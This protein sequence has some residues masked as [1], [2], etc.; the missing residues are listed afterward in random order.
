MLESIKSRFFIKLIFS[1]IEEEKKLKIVKYSKMLQNKI[2]INLTNYKFF[3]GKYIKYETKEKIKGKEF[4]IL[5]DNLIFEGEYKNCSRNGK[6]KEYDYNG[7]LLFEGEYLNGKRNGK[8]FEYCCSGNVIK[9]EGEYL[10][11]LRMGKG[12]EY[13]AK[14]K[15]LFEVEYLNGQ[16]WNGKFKEFNYFNQLIPKKL[17]Y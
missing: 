14:G 11:G 10:N 17:G 16:R 5:N 2:D 9:F 6:G 12:K 8:G 4:N 1:L 15:I 13:N 7:N 3:S